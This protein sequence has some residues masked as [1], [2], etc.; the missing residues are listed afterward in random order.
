MNTVD[1]IL[2][3]GVGDIGDTEDSDYADGLDTSWV[4]AIERA[5]S[6]VRNPYLKESMKV[7]DCHFI[8]IDGNMAITKIVSEKTE[9]EDLDS[10]MGNDRIKRGIHKDRLLQLVQ[11]KRVHDSKKYKLIHWMQFHVGLDPENT[12]AFLEKNDIDPAD[13]VKTPSYLMDLVVEDSIFV[14][15][16]INS[17]FFFFKEAE[18]TRP[19]KTMKLVL[20][21][22][23]RFTKKKVR[24]S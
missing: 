9:L 13:F 8:F 15:H 22:D 14:F 23:K 17:L 6:D 19:G 16:D 3:S 5:H 18:K 4:D 24:F 11:N 20:E 21:K 1:Q 2:A 7:L 10:G 12:S